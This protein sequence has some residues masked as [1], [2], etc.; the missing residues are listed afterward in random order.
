[1]DNS[2]MY[3]NAFDSPNASSRG[4]RMPANFDLASGRLQ[5]YDVQQSALFVSEARALQ[6]LANISGSS[7]ALA[8][9]PQL[10][11]R[12][13]SM[14]AL[15]NSVLWDESSGIYRQLDASAAELGFSPAISPTSFYP[16]IR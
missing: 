11:A 1:M 2:P 15:I 5:L 7:A 13:D 12:A 10:K 3:F 16:M 6:Q 8:A 14:A 4:K 9:V